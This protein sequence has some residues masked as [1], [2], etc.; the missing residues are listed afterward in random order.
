MTLQQFKHLSEEGREY[1]L[2]TKAVHIASIEG[3]DNCL[4]LFQVDSFYLEV[5]TLNHS[6]KVK[7]LVFF[8]EVELLEPYLKRI[9]IDDLKGLI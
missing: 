5:E 9:D 3:Y 2:S 1:V 8:E 6:Q 7:T 4:D